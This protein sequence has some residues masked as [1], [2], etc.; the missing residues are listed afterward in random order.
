M[1][2]TESAFVVLRGLENVSVKCKVG[3]ERLGP[4]RHLNEGAPVHGAQLEPGVQNWTV[5][6]PVLRLTQ[7]YCRWEA[8]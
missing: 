3:A 4:Q 8:V 2:S 6:P 7:L 1:K 5:G